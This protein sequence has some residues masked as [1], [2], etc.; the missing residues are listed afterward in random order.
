MAKEKIYNIF[1]DNRS[2][3]LIANFKDGYT[4]DFH[5]ALPEVFRTALDI[6]KTPRIVEGSTILE[7]SQGKNYDF[8]AGDIIYDNKIAYEVTWGE[9]KKK[10]NRF[11]KILQ[12]TPAY[13]ELDESIMLPD[14]VIYTEK[15]NSFSP[16]KNPPS[17][18][19]I[20]K[21]RYNQGT[22]IFQLYSRSGELEDSFAS[23]EK[24]LSQE[25]FV[26]FLQTGK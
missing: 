17:K 22:V 24:T 16:L 10:L 12:A 3:I 18:I 13:D 5:F 14:P 6:Q 15:S 1:G 19:F 2:P 25:Q 8:K 11:L 4:C 23:E 26:K 9:A 20:R 7:Y 21:Y